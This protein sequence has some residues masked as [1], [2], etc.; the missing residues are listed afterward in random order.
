[1]PL[2]C[3]FVRLTRV[4]SGRHSIIAGR[5]TGEMLLHWV[6]D[7]GAANRGVVRM[8]ALSM[9][10]CALSKAACALRRDLSGCDAESAT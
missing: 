1:M 5:A 10:A 9:V 4:P 7:G 3:V 2:C 8:L 6:L